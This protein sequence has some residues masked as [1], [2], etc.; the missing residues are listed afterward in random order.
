MTK[1]GREW[2][3]LFSGRFAGME[4]TFFGCFAEIP[5]LIF[6]VKCADSRRHSRES[7]NPFLPTNSRIHLV[8]HKKMR[9]NS[10]L[11]FCVKFAKFQN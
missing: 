4:C 8:F 3:V 6:R 10:K 9:G 11:N 2:N 5:K 1:N 7:G